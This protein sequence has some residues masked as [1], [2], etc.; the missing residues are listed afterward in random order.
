MSI[1]S[2]DPLTAKIT[3]LTAQ[4]ISDEILGGTIKFCRETGYKQTA[5]MLAFLWS[6]FLLSAKEELDEHGLINSILDCCTRSIC[7]AIP[8][9]AGNSNIQ[10]QIDELC[11][12]YWEN[13][14]KDF[15]LLQG[16]SEVSAFL[17]IATKL[18]SPDDPAAAY[19]L[20]TN[21]V[22]PFLQISS[23]IRSNIFRIIFQVDNGFTVQYRGILNEFH[24]SATNAA[25]G[26]IR[27]GRQSNASTSNAKRKALKGWKKISIVLLLIVGLVPILGNIFN[28]LAPDNQATSAPTL[29]PVLEPQSGTILS[30]VENPYGNKLTVITSSGSSYVVKLKTA[31]GLTRLTFYVRAGDTVTVKAPSEPLYVY[32]ASG[33]TWYGDKYLFG[34]N[35][36]YTMDAEIRDFTQARYSLEYT[37]YPVT[38]GNF[39]E[40]P[41]DADD[42]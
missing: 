6:G 8:Q 15:S 11:R 39:T 40:T 1:S 24:S 27:N 17:Q 5:K 14:S 9:F 23:H 33:E 36:R 31:S 35:T 37:L 18:N 13:L 26:S 34:N 3:Y 30:G 20:K 21:P 32:F 10:S 7:Q 28:I 4:I 16:E 19:L 38:N 42:F 2:S 12:H 29:P 41:I 25:S 22:Q